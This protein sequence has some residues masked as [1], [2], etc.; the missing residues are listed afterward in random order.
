MTTPSWRVRYHE[1][2]SRC[3]AVVATAPHLHLSS[4]VEGRPRGPT[5]QAQLRIHQNFNHYGLGGTLAG[6]N[7][8]HYGLGGTLAPGRGAWVA[9]QQGG[10]VAAAE[11]RATRA[12][13]GL[14]YGTRG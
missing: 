6:G 7:F 12:G 5:A 13:T 8:N 11:G 2:R 3:S 1:N 10:T 14:G 9:P 4:A